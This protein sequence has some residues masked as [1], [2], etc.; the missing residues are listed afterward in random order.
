MS[1]N[2]NASNTSESDES[3]EEDPADHAH[4]SKSALKATN[5]LK[6]SPKNLIPRTNAYDPK[7]YFHEEDDDEIVT[8]NMEGFQLAQFITNEK[9]SLL[10]LFLKRDHEPTLQLFYI[11]NTEEN[12]IQV[13]EPVNSSIDKVIV[14]LLDLA[15]LIGGKK[16]AAHCIH[17]W[18]D[19]SAVSSVEA[20]R[21]ISTFFQK[22]YNEIGSW[23]V[24]VDLSWAKSFQLKTFNKPPQ[25][26]SHSIRIFHYI[27]LGFPPPETERIWMKDTAFSRGSW[28]NLSELRS[29]LTPPCLLIFDCDNAAILRGYLSK[30]ENHLTMYD[31]NSAQTF[32]V[33]FACTA[34]EQLHIA[35]TLPQ[36]FFSCILLS[37]DLSFSAIT[38]IE[39]PNNKLETFNTLL[40]LFTETIALDSLPYLTYQLLFRSNNII[41]VMWCRFMLAQRLMKNFGL[42]S[43]SIP[44][45][46]DMS[47]HLLWK[48]FEYSLMCMDKFN[49]IEQ[50]S[51]LYLRHFESVPH[52]PKYVCAF[53]ANL[54]KI[55][56]QKTNV[57]HHIAKFMK[58]SPANCRAMGEVLNFRNIGDYSSLVRGS[59][60]EFI[61]WCVVLSGM[62]FAI[63][64]LAKL[65]APSF[66]LTELTKYALDPKNKEES[67][68]HLFSIMVSFRDS[69]THF[70]CFY[71]NEQ[72]TEKLVP[73]LFTSTP[74]IREWI[75]LL[76]HAMIARFQVD[77]KETGNTGLHA[78]MMLLLYDEQIFTR[79]AAIAILTSLM[80][81]HIPVFNTN[82][83]SCALKGAMD[84]SFDV[85]L[86]LLFAIARYMSLNE[87]AL[88]E[89]MNLTEPIDY[90]LRKDPLKFTEEEIRAPIYQ[91][92]K[93]F[94]TNPHKK[95]S[96]IANRLLQE[97]AY[98]DRYMENA[99]KIHTKAHAVLFSKSPVNCEMD[100]RYGDYLFGG[101]DL[102][103]FEV[104]TTQKAAITDLAFDYE[105]KDIAYGSSEGTF[106]WGEN[107]WNVPGS[108]VSIISLHHMA[109]A[110]SS[111][112][113]SVYLFRNGFDKK[114][115]VIQPSIDPPNG[116][117]LIGSVPNE[118]NIFIC[119]GNNDILVWNTYSILL[120]DHISIPS[121]VTQFALINGGLY[122]V[123]QS[124]LIIKLD[125]NNFAIE[126]EYKFHEGHKVINIGIHHDKIYTVLDNGTV[127]LWN[128]SENPEIYKEFP[129]ASFLMIHSTTDQAIKIQNS[130]ATL[131]NLNTNQTI[132]MHPERKA[133]KACFDGSRPLCSI[134]NEDGSV[135]VWRLPL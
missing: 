11:P 51:E 57:L 2:S 25:N 23:P 105:H 1:Y 66:S 82:V 111:T 103:L 43:Q 42:H 78:N 14:H 90:F 93:F 73:L 59:E 110:V 126:Y 64:S 114:I 89:S 122:A 104:V 21:V 75:T 92:L 108:V 4:P 47:E 98:T 113:H 29:T 125:T 80:T 132:E 60:E 95:L 94:S 19:V 32:F 31:R 101:H 46:P 70:T 67:R 128:D 22:Q 107:Y 30:K 102:E 18:C 5:C 61:D 54:L 34:T 9:S 41:S 63:P 129:G 6:D 72:T 48:M 36:N 26:L 123:L 118:P 124:G 68:I 112:N 121:P 65:I 40:E 74:A 120:I 116:P 99:I 134:G 88:K 133:V 91:V 81:P 16:Q 20:K 127:Y 10:D 56:D 62:L 37:P 17:S 44:E 96:K 79:V 77:A 35:S 85:K 50:L 52:P 13:P 3:S 8:D 38:G 83:M 130:V 76:I 39:I 49:P 27:G 87:N 28:T 117:T 115:H 71:S 7:Q 55:P 58:Q 106:I 119:Q 109:F 97:T 135:S 15:A 33:F 24:K 86:A 53:V 12:P 45:L 84:G 100:Q 131:V 69:Q